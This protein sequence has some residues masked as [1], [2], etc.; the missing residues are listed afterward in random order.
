[1]WSRLQYE[2]NKPMILKRDPASHKTDNGVVAIVG[3]SETMHGAPLF[4]ALAAEASGVD[5]VHVCLPRLHQEVAKRTSLNFQVHPFEGDNIIDNDQEKILELLAGMD[6]AVIGPGIAYNENSTEVVKSIAAEAVCP[7]VL[8]AAALQPSTLSATK[9]SQVVVTPHL[10]E[11]ERM[12]IDPEKIGEE[13][14]KFESAIF[15]KGQV[16]KIAL[17]D[18]STE[19]IEGGNAG[20]TVG[21]SGDALSGLICGLIAQGMD[22]NEACI[23]A[24]SIIKNAGEALFKEKGYAYTTEDIIDQIPKLLTSYIE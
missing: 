11:L 1:M 15:L 19:T 13:A 4:A 21:G 16:D 5:L 7:L 22:T 6:C 8:D 14:R 2:Y 17:P 20:L 18:G 9:G 3:G 23:T 10:G 12:E 24:G